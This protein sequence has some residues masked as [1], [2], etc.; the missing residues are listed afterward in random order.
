M[1][2]RLSKKKSRI[3]GIGVW[4]FAAVL[5]TGAA[6]CQAT[7]AGKPFIHRVDV[8][9]GYSRVGPSPYAQTSDNPA[10]T[11]FGFGADVHFSKWLAV[12]AEADWMR[13]TY[14]AEDK[15]KSVSVLGGP[16][17]FFPVSHHNVIIPFADVLGGVYTFPDPFG[18]NNPF[19]GTVS[20]AFAIDGGVDVHI[21]GP[22]YVRGQ[23]GYVYSGFNVADT[24]DQR[25]V[26]NQHSR[27]LVEG[28]WRF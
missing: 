20:P 13:V 1:F 25:F 2:R 24:V 7:D 18:F 11:G 12:A 4:C 16:R 3:A 23:G 14:D 19:R 26:H 17:L 21:A 28:V 5:F 15:S 22:V 9:G 27:V 10:D 6:W 8:Y